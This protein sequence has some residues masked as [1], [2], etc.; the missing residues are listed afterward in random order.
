MS[1][2]KVYCSMNKEGCEWIGELRE[3]DVHTQDHCIHVAM[4]CT[5][6]CGACIKRKE[7]KTHELDSCPKRSLEV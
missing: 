4:E 1:T 5:L 2:G 3:L 6:G 7:L